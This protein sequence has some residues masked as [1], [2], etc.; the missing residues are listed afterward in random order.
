MLG[1]DSSHWHSNLFS[2]SH[3]KFDEVSDNQSISHLIYKVTVG[4]SRHAMNKL[5]KIAKKN[6]ISKLEF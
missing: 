4:W 3:V 1:K 2:E 5:L 6:L